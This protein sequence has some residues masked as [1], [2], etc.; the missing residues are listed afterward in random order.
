M[1]W[2][3]LL[4]FAIRLWGWTKETG[5]YTT[6]KKVKTREIPGGSNSPEDSKKPVVQHSK[7]DSP[8]FKTSGDERRKIQPVRCLSTAAQLLRHQQGVVAVDLQQVEQEEPV[9]VGIQAHGPHALLGERGIGAPCHLAE[10]LENPVVLL[11]EK[12]AYVKIKKE[13]GIIDFFFN[14]YYLTENMY[15][16]EFSL[17]FCCPCPVCFPPTFLWFSPHVS[18]VNSNSDNQE[19]EQKK[20]LAQNST[21]WD[22]ITPVTVRGGER[23]GDSV[24]P[25]TSLIQF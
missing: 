5:T 22:L 11:Q 14:I 7:L 10:G 2:P 15:R 18:M 16:V 21:L 24:G 3:L 23:P 9:S 12:P 13:G 4:P 20:N 8:F 25:I 1:S 19:K 17:L 6:T